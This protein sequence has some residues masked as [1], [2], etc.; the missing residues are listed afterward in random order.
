MSHL[1]SRLVLLILVLS[2]PC[3]SMAQVSITEVM[4]DLEG[5]D[6]GRE[7]VEIYNNGSESVD[8]LEWRFVEGGKNHLLKEGGPIP[9][10]SYAIIADDRV[11]FMSEHPGVSV[12]VFDSVTSLS[13]EGEVIALLN[14]EKIEVDSVVYSL[15]MGAAGDGNSLQYVSSGWY[16][17]SPTPGS[18]NTRTVKQPTGVDPGDTP[19]PEPSSVL[20]VVTSSPPVV[21]LVPT[22]YSD[23]SIL[24]DIGPQEQH[25]FVGVVMAFHSR[26]SGIPKNWERNTRFFWSLG[27]GSKAVGG[28]IEHTFL[29]EG[30]Y[31]VT[32][33]AVSGEY[34]G[35]GRVYVDVVNPDV[36]IQNISKERGGYIELASRMKHDI[37][38]GAWKLKFRGEV[39]SIPSYT[40]LLGG[41]RLMLPH[42]VTG[43]QLNTGD[44]ALLSPD[45]VTV[46]TYTVD[47]EVL[48][49]VSTKESVVIPDIVVPVT[50]HISQTDIVGVPT[51]AR[52]SAPVKVNVKS[53]EYS[54]PVPRVENEVFEDSAMKGIPVEDEQGIPKQVASVARVV[55]VEESGMFWGLLGVSA[56][57]LIGMY[58]VIIHRQRREMVESD[59][60]VHGYTIVEHVSK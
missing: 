41:Q 45:N 16:P 10:Q 20:P 6:K 47:A 54:A 59:T 46:D 11:V 48:K 30:R 26:A 24:V 42:S 17:G 9:S 13:N 35:Q 49:I 51:S 56:I 28:D 37:D 15:D 44:V 34:S 43:L 40:F 52:E 57:A 8:I 36:F 2:F 32:A 3:I 1:Q 58:G 5:S 4:Y 18:S 7:W 21:S 39:F 31:V 25:S 14:E 60:L 53:V 50:P 19:S 27:D 33:T 23:T 29:H 22:T 38:L 12:P 55:P